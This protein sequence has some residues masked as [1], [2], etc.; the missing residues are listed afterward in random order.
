MSFNALEVRSTEDVIDTIQLIWNPAGRESYLR[1]GPKRAVPKTKEFE[2]NLAFHRSLTLGVIKEVI[3]LLKKS[4]KAG[5][6]RLAQERD[7][8]LYSYPLKV[9]EEGMVQV[10]PTE[11]DTNLDLSLP[12]E[13]VACEWSGSFWEATDQDFS[14]DKLHEVQRSEGLDNPKTSDLLPPLTIT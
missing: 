5:T 9:N 13:W 1:Q 11:H 8:Y 14:S 4:S 10:L 3:A 2:C 12:S 6:V 7:F